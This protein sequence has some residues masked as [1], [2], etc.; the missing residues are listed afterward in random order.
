MYNKCYWTTPL[1]LHYW[2]LIQMSVYTQ[3][4]SRRHQKILR[5][6][7]EPDPRLSSGA[8]DLGV[9]KGNTPLN[10]QCSLVQG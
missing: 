3:H 8:Q 10:S 2:V 6:Y 4:S 1:E 9:I 7:T 5:Y